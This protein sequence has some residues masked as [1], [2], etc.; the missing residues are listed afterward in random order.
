MIRTGL[1][2]VESWLMKEVVGGPP[3]HLNWSME[4]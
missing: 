4:L 1:S 3:F 2:Q